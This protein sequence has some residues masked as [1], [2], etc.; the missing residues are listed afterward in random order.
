MSLNVCSLTGNLLEKPVFSKK[1]GHV[2]EK[3]SIEKHIDSTGQCP[4]TGS[5]LTRDDLLELNYQSTTIIPSGGSKIPNTLQKIQSEWDSM[6][7][8]NFNTKRQLD[9]IKKEISQTLYQ[10]EA[11]NLVIRRLIKE[12]DEAVRQ[13]NAFRMQVDE[14]QEKEEEELDDNNEFDYMGVYAELQDR[15]SDLSSQLSTQRKVR[16]ISPNLATTEAI[17]SY[18][19]KGS[20]PFH[21]ASKPGILS[22]NIHPHF[23]GLVLTGGVDG[24]AVL[25][26]ADKEKVLH[27][28][29]KAHSKKINN[30]EFYPSSD[31]IGF[32][33][34]SAD[35]TAS[36]WLSEQSSDIA[37]SKMNERY[38]V[39]NHTNQIMDSSFHPLKEYCLFASK[40]A[41][42]SFHS[43]FKGV[44]LVKQKSDNELNAC[45]FHPDGN[46]IFI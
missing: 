18:K 6:V 29:D 16:Q 35:N 12:R 2:Y 42:W 22:V 3:D 11:A 45:E 46:Q 41:S 24:K 43:L 36:L 9:E 40:D 33:L 15:I 4:I 23:D 8:D 38:Q 37:S 34:T 5:E 13:M 17:N 14:L 20:Y 30:V 21:S 1:T 25:F 19:V 26:D 28:L 27:S 10:H 31:I 7:L 32:T 44:C 39:T